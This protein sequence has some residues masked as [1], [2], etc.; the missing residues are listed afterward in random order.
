VKKFLLLIA[1]SLI[2][3]CLG[4]VAVAQE[5]PGLLAGQVT[6]EILNLPLRKARIT[7][8]GTSL[9]AYSDAEGFYRIEKIPPGVYAVEAAA[10]GYEKSVAREVTVV[11]DRE[12]KLDFVLALAATVQGE[13][14][15]VRDKPP[16]LDTSP[17]TSAHTFTREEIE[18]KSG[19]FEDVAKAMKQLP[20]VVSNTDFSAD[21]FV[22]GAN[23]YE[24]IIILDRIVMFN[25]YHF[26]AGLTVINTDLI[27]DFTFYAG[28]FPAEYFFAMGS[29][30]DVRYRDGNKER[31]DGY[32]SASLISA[33]TW[34]SG[35]L[36]TPK[37]TWLASARRSYYDWLLKL[38]DVTDVPVPVFS[39]LMLKTTVNP[40]QKHKITA[41][42]LRSE[43]GLDLEL[44]EENPSS[45]DE[46]D[47]LYANLQQLFALDWRWLASKHLFFDTTASYQ[48][49]NTDASV[50][51]TD[52]VGANVQLNLWYVRH[53]T[54]VIPADTHEIKLG[55]V[56][57]VMHIDAEILAKLEDW[58][59][60]ANIP[61]EAKF[62]RTYVE[63]DLDLSFYGFHLQDDFE[64]IPKRWRANLGVRADH[65][66]A[67]GEGWDYSPRAS[68]SVNL[69]E[70]LVLKAAFG[71]YY[72]F[73]YNLLATDKKL[74]NPD[75]TS[76]RAFHY[77]LGGEYLLTENMLLRI[78]SYYKWFD[79]LMFQQIDWRSMNLFGYEIEYFDPEQDIHWYNSG[80]GEAYGVEVFFQKRMAD[81]WDGWLAYTFAVVQR[82][83]GLGES[84]WFYPFQDQRH[85]VNLVGN[86]RPWKTWT[87]SFDFSFHT[88]KPYTPIRG[89]EK[90][91]AGTPFVYWE[92][93]RGGLNS[94]R[95]P[96]YHR[97]NLRAEKLWRIRDRIDLSAFLEIFN[98][99]NQRNVYTY[100]YTE[101]DVEEKPERKTFY[102]LPFL[103]YF[104]VKAEF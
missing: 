16:V 23:N 43:D 1:F 14:V 86:L 54:T 5:P 96:A 8:E 67:N 10:V 101:Q 55:A 83:D 22:R 78:E 62:V 97:L 61:D 18:S 80:Y 4:E 66:Q 19:A 45:V 79:D 102:E 93:K 6:D 20:G 77:V 59:P 32:G 87:F 85:T 13:E 40:N 72:V 68:T 27:R 7:I 88:G 38:F 30:L 31:I 35:P 100:F 90:K 37:V 92:P 98:V 3:L 39:D 34:L 11:S 56:G 75:L 46:G 64:I 28:G 36:F 71:I 73:P 44:T 82:N 91:Y 65:Y 48:I 60:G 76:E 25:P 103:P 70:D 104:G 50:T 63:R 2:A 69:T 29:I 9:V 84:G 51:G 81:W 95:F 41:M 52:P 89:W 33:S 26:G 17:Q 47:A 15:V 42:A 49:Q 24:N 58:L 99:Y 21:M 74:G 57:G 94:A 53:D 12:T